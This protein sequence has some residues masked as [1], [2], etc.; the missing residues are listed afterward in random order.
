[1]V[2]ILVWDERLWLLR[3]HKWNWLWLIADLCLLLLLMHGQRLIPGVEWL[4]R[5]LELWSAHSKLTLRI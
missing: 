4:G 3:R 1:L 5:R 2:H